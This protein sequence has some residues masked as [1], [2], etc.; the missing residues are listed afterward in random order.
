MA[1]SLLAIRDINHKY[2]VERDVYMKKRISIIVCILIVLGIIVNEQTDFAKGSISVS[3]L[4][5]KNFQVQEENISVLDTPFQGRIGISIKNSVTIDG[6]K[7]YFL[8]TFDDPEKA[9]AKIKEEIPNVLKALS[10]T[11]Q[12][13]ELTGKNWKEYQGMLY[14]YLD[15]ENKAE[16]Y[17]EDNEEFELAEAFFDYYENEEINKELLQFLSSI[18]GSMNAEQKMECILMLP[19]TEPLVAR[20]DEIRNEIQQESSSSSGLMAAKRSDNLKLSKAVR[21]AGYYAILSNREQYGFFDGHDCTNFVSQILEVAGQEQINPMF[22]PS[23]GW[24]HYQDYKLEH[25]HSRAW[26]NANAFG[27]YWSVDV[28]QT[29]HYLFSLQLQVGDFILA[30]G[31][32]NG[33]WDHAGFVTEVSDSMFKDQYG[34]YYRNYKVAQHTTNYHRWANDEKNGWV[35]DNQKKTYGIVRFSYAKSNYK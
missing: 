28:K 4:E 29:S 19:Y 25:H 5:V 9:T 13:E 20:A 22:I 31:D 21:Y 1:D 24:W 11:Y 33:T 14:R 27:N 10:E 23:N 26:V 16:W 7:N 30:D 35:K 18:N 8:K 3:N 15:E 17:A 32:K 6:E 12:L 2:V 34:V